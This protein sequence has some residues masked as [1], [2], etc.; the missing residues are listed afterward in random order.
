VKESIKRAIHRVIKEQEELEEPTG[1]GASYRELQAVT[2]HRAPSGVRQYIGRAVERLGYMQEVDPDDTDELI[3]YGVLEFIALLLD[4]GTID[5]E[6]AMELKMNPQHVEEM[7]LFRN[8]LTDGIMLP[9]FHQVKRNAKKEVAAQ[10]AVLGI[11]ETLHDRIKNFIVDDPDRDEQ[12]LLADI[13]TDIVSAGQDMTA[14][15]SL[16]T[17]LSSELQNLYD[18]AGLKPNISAIAQKKWDSRNVNDKLRIMD[19]AG[20]KG[21]TT[22]IGSA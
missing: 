12:K 19:K 9:A 1:D 7:D 14:A 5:E 11:P 6:D 15:E 21:S 2:G 13:K 20:S 8:F 4:A 22:A 18:I 17:A 16:A 10:L 3:A